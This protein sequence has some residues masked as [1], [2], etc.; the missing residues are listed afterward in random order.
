MRPAHRTRISCLTLILVA[1]AHPVA[2]Q[3]VATDEVICARTWQGREAE[4][5]AYMRQAPILRV[6]PIP[7]GVTAPMRAF[8]AEDGLVSSVAWKPIR[9]GI[10]RGRRES[11]RSEIAGYILDRLLGL[12]MVPPTIERRHRG[13]RGAAILWI[14][15]VRMWS[16][17]KEDEFPKGTLW[18]MQII[19]QRMFDNLIANDDRNQGN[20]LIDADGHLSLI[21]H[22]RAFGVGRSLVYDLSR[23]DA[24]LWE[25]M[26][27]LSEP[28]LKAAIG[29]WLDGGQIRAILRRRDDM[30]RHIEKLVAE[31]GEAQVLLRV[32]APHE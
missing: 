30:A 22:S 9:P 14:G 25:A 7:L 23:V 21:D 24:E 2:A 5:E 13:D 4:F 31:R 18:A 26:T 1:L 8:F 15:P 32:P 17:L 10:Q 3:P 29:P 28:S 11:Y 20:L 27:R 16:D 6:E 12:G 19:R